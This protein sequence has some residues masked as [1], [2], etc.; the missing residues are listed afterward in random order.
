MPSAIV[1]KLEDHEIRANDFPTVE[2]LFSGRGLTAFCRQL[3]GETSLTG[4]AA[5]SLYGDPEQQQLTQAIDTYAALL[6]LLLRDFSLS[7]MPSHGTFLAG[8]VGRA[9]AASASAP[10]I[11]VFHEPCQFRLQDKPPIFVAKEDSAALMGC[12][13]F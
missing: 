2:T 11:K 6:G 3:T 13:Q 7:Y 10:L 12:A 9:I 1:S 8:S 4:E 5:I